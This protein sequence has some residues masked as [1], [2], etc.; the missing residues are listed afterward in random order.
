MFFKLQGHPLGDDCKTQFM[1]CKQL[2][3]KNETEWD[4]LENKSSSHLVYLPSHAI[5]SFVCVCCVYFSTMSNIILSVNP[6]EEN[7]LL[8]KKI[9]DHVWKEVGEPSMDLI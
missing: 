4:K 3:Y 6:R 7:G 8:G 9:R 5:A 2:F 1:H